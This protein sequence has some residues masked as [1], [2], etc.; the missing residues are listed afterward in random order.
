MIVNEINT[1]SPIKNTAYW[2]SWAYKTG[3]C[4]LRPARPGLS[5]GEKQHGQQGRSHFEENTFPFRPKDDT[6]T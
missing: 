3:A 6:S 1:Q 2:I 5:F 4:P